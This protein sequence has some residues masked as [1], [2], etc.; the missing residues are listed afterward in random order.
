MIG[1]ETVETILPLNFD[2]TILLNDQHLNASY[3]TVLYWKGIKYQVNNILLI[4]LFVDKSFI[5]ST[6]FLLDKLLIFS[7][8]K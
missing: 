6:F 7:D 8:Q 3:K 1:V 2:F 5:Y 4:N